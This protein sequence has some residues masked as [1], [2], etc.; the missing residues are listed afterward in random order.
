HPFGLR[1]DVLRNVRPKS[2]VQQH[3]IAPLPATSTL[4]TH[5]TRTRS[6]DRA[7]RNT[8]CARTDR[9]DDRTHATDSPRARTAIS[10]H[11]SQAGEPATDQRLQVARRSQRSGGV[12]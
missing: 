3:E 10:G 11:P 12:T 4:T 6:T 8:R 1:Q 2:V 7:I 5:A 9:E